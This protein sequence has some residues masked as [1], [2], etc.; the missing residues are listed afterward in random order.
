MTR[1][2]ENGAG[3]DG[4]GTDDSGETPD[5]RKIYHRK[6]TP[7][8]DE[9]NQ[10]LLRSIAD[11]ERCAVT[12]LPP[13]YEQVDHLIEHLFNSPPPPEAHAELQ[14]SYHGYRIELDQTGNATLMKLADRMS[15]GS[16]E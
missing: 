16:D 5:E 12:D 13:L 4:D 7:D 10:S 14:F 11:L 2:N 1:G 3:G 15:V 9:A 6:V 8:P